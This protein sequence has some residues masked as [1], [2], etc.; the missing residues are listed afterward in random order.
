ME[1]L[2]LQSAALTHRVR[3]ETTMGQIVKFLK[4]IAAGAVCM[5]AAQR[6]D[7]IDES[8]KNVATG[9]A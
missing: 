9:N 3:K 6:P 8:M 1:F 2:V 4:I 7:A 5:A